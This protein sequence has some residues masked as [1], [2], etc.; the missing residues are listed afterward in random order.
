MDERRFSKRHYEAIAALFRAENAANPATKHPY[1]FAED[2]A[3]MLEQDSPFRFDR[4]RF[5]KACQPAEPDG[6]HC[7]RCENDDPHNT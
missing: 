6:C 7:F 1:I 2:A 5:L 3:N 4:E